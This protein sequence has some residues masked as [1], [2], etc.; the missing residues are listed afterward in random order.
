MLSHLQNDSL[1]KIM[2]FLATP[3]DLSS[4]ILISQRFHEIFLQAI[5]RRQIVS[6]VAKNTKFSVLRTCVRFANLTKLT[7]EHIPT[8]SD[9]TFIHIQYLPLQELHIISC[10]ISDGALVYFKH[11]TQLRKLN[12]TNCCKILGT[13]FANIKNLPLTYL[14]LKNLKIQNIALTHLPKSLKQLILSRCLYLTDIALSY[15]KHL[16][17][18]Y[19]SISHCIS[20]TGSNFSSLENLPLKSLHASRT[21]IDDTCIPVLKKFPLTELKFKGNPITDPTLTSCKDMPLCFLSLSSCINLT[22]YCF[23][24][25]QHKALTSL[26]LELCSQVNDETLSFLQAMPLR[27]LNLRGCRKIKDQGMTYLKSLPLQSLNLSYCTITDI[28]LLTLQNLLLWH[29]DLEGCNIT[30]VGIAYVQKMPLSYLNVSFCIKIT[31]ICLMHLQYTPLECLCLE[32]CLI[33][34]K[35]LIYL[36]PLSHLI[37]KNCKI[38]NKC[39]RIIQQHPPQKLLDLSGCKKIKT[40][41]RKI[42]EGE[43]LIHFKNTNFTLFRFKSFWQLK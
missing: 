29:L 21:K 37:L 12:L 18:E 2:S 27:C 32:S 11:L 38:T 14:N 39:L 10:N 16:H 40:R 8:L 36:M 23:L 33:K 15:L 24:P 34:D 30:D 20:I 6:F 25:L 41:Y 26:N 13:A 35:D 3:Q 22:A 5:Q 1:G 43:E 9:I 17:L 4:F 19:L 31:G 28:G 42:W 7:L